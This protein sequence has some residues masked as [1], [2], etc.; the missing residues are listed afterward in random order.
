MYLGLESKQH[1]TASNSSVS[2]AVD[3]QGV[4]LQEISDM[5]ATIKATVDQ[6]ATHVN[7]NER[8]IDAL[9]QYGR[10]NCLILHGSM[11]PAS[12][13]TSEPHAFENHVINISNTNL[14]LTK[15]IT[16][17][18]IDICHPLP[19]AKNKYPII[20]KFVRRTVRNAVFFSQKG[21]QIN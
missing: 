21:P 7:Q 4:Q 8:N 5:I 10:S 3:A 19:S 15:P 12:S 16:N 11:Q 2:N 18:D 9:E 6:L 14:N 17:A 20:I 1:A 13:V